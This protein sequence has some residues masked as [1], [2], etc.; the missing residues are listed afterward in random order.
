[1]F[2]GKKVIHLRK[3]HLLACSASTS[4]YKFEE[5]LMALINELG[6]ADGMF[7][8]F[9]DDLDL[10]VRLGGMIDQCVGAIT[11]DEY[12][13]HVESNSILR[14][15]FHPVDLPEH[16]TDEIIKL[17]K[18]LTVRYEAHHNV[19]Y[20]DEALTA[21]AHLS[22]LH[23]G[24]GFL[25]DKAI[26]MID[27]AG[28]RVSL[29]MTSA[30]AEKRVVTQHH[31]EQL[32]PSAKKCLKRA[33]RD[34]PNKSKQL[35]EL[36]EALKKHVV[37]QKEAVEVISRALL[38]ARVGI[39]DTR[40][41][42]ASFF[43]TGPTGVGK[44]ELANAVAIEYFGSINSMKR[45]DMSEYKERHSVSKLFGSPPGYVSNHEGGQLTNTIL[46]NPRTVLLFDEIEKAHEDVY[47][48]FLQMLEDGRL[49]DGRGTIVDFTNTII[50]FTSN[51]GYSL[52][53]TASTNSS[54]GSRGPDYHQLKWMV[55][56]ELKKVFRPELLNRL[57]D[58]LVFRQL[59]RDDMGKVLE[60]MLSK[61]CQRVKAMNLTL[62]IR[63]S[64]KKKLI[65]EGY[66]PAF[67]A[68]PMRRCITRVVEDALAEW[69]ADGDV[70]KGNSVVMD[71]DTHGHVVKYITLA[72]DREHAYAHDGVHQVVQTAHLP[73]QQLH[74]V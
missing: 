64:V 19:K 43:F 15:C 2:Q 9:L 55:M 4:S 47:D 27:E 35:H 8:L 59:T 40:R 25:I 20:M 73:I 63:D 10:L 24:N 49:T 45:L 56:E 72:L 28:A 14:D 46:E 67:G 51:V 71:V 74:P 11:R 31:I 57:D 34:S 12:E 50:I 37:G 13:K 26:D 36:E 66:D 58:V 22:C 5:R 69:I 7:I 33:P 54:S 52:F 38:R 60:L 23:T 6:K 30:S 53:N 48:A 62:E 39:R 61:V 17:L 70:R 42:V 21:A 44:T 32:I 29:E 1:M 16:S 18:V 41:P 68:R 65:E 3:V